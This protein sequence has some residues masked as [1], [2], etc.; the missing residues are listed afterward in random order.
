M[1][2]TVTTEISTKAEDDSLVIQ[3]RHDREAFGQLYLLYYERVL[4]FCVHRLFNRST[5][6]DAT[7]EIFLTAAKKLHGFKG[8]TK[9]EFRNWIY[10]IA[11]N[12]TSDYIRKYKHRNELLS[13]A[14]ESHRLLPQKGTNEQVDSDWSSLY[15]AIVQVSIYLLMMERYTKS[16]LPATI[17]YLI[18]TYLKLFLYSPIFLVNSS[19]FIS[20][21]L[22]ENKASI[23]DFPYTIVYL[24]PATLLSRFTNRIPNL[25]RKHK[26]SDFILKLFQQEHLKNTNLTTDGV[27]LL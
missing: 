15:R 21:A 11:C 6:E 2:D 1:A 14:I 18:T 19:R 7:S 23:W 27:P 13:D 26:I 17:V 12:I 10:T 22:N 25:S 20:N 24:S 5:A 4:R 8:R 3:A 16:M 9:R